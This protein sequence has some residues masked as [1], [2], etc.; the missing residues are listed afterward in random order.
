MKCFSLI[1][2]S[3]FKNMPRKIFLVK[4]TKPDTIYYYFQKVLFHK[5]PGSNVKQYF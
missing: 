5:L 3:V 2:N 1:K 4:W